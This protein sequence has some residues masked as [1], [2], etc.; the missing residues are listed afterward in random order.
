MKRLD[1]LTFIRFLAVLLVLIYHGGA[2]DYIQPINVFPIS[3]LLRSAPAAVSYLYVLSGFVMSLA[4][5][6]PNERFDAGAF[7]KA[8]I[9][10]IYPLYIISFLL[11]VFYYIDFIAR[12]KPPKILANIFVLQAWYPPYAQS[13]N[14]PSWSMT[15]EFFF[16]AVF[17]LF[18]IWAY[19]QTTRKLIS[20]SVALWIGSQIAHYFLWMFHFPEWELFIVYF[21]PF[22]LNSFILGAVGGIWFLREGQRQELKPIFISLVFVGSLLLA[23]AFLILGALYPQIPNDLQ[24]MAGLFSPV[25]VLVIVSLALDRSRFSLILQHP[26]LMALGESAYAIYILQAPVFWIYERALLSSTLHNPQSIIDMTYLPLMIL[27]GLGAHFY[28]DQ[29]LRR[30]L[31]SVLNRVSIPLLLLD[32]AAVAVSIYASFHFRFSSNRDLMEFKYAAYAMFWCAFI[33]RPVITVIFNG[34]NPLML[35]LSVVQMLKPI[36]IS[37][38]VG[39][40]LLGGLLFSFVSMGWLDSFPR[41]IL[42]YDLGLLLFLSILSRFVFRTAS[43]YKLNR[44]PA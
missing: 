4:Y 36:L 34:N 22:H 8:R 5:Y 3:V 42:I 15:V 9:I 20:V 18:T 37:V 16:Y 6:K 43:I 39:T 26:W 30:W 38:T 12:I 13:F 14:Y 7:W 28:V 25:F 40:L 29:P 10:R 21:P 41:S 35:N 19:R 31:R 11:V 33:V 23:S 2:G 17:P 1:Q 32:L 24:P 27:I 44:A